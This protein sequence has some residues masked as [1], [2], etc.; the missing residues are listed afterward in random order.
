MA[1]LSAVPLMYMSVY[2]LQW[3]DDVI[4]CVLDS[5]RLGRTSFPGSLNRRR[6]FSCVTLSH[7]T[8]RR[9]KEWASGYSVANPLKTTFS[10]L[11][12]S[13][14]FHRWVPYLALCFVFVFDKFWM[15]FEFLTNRFGCLDFHAK[16]LLQVILNKWIKL[17]L[18]YWLP[19]RRLAVSNWVHNLFCSQ[20]QIHV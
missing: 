20:R 12:S 5:H 9:S 19:E 4:S 11:T 7:I 6:L 1:V 3:T 16:I 13:S 17:V 14:V 15:T 18:W 2:L 8:S 10:R